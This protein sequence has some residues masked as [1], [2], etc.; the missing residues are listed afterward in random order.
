MTGPHACDACAVMVDGV[1]PDHSSKLVDLCDLKP[2]TIEYTQSGA[3]LLPD[4][5]ASPPRLT[6]CPT[7]HPHASTLL[8]ACRARFV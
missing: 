1:A 7:H 3:S 5:V 6:M 8:W 4:V 2:A